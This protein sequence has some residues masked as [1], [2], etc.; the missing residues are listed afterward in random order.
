MKSQSAAEAAISWLGWLFHVPIEALTAPTEFGTDL[1][2]TFTSDF[3]E[4][5]LATVS[6]EVLYV[7]R[8]MRQSLSAAEPVRSVGDFCSLI[9]H[10]QEMDPIGY[11]RLLARWQKHMT[12]GSKP[13][14]RRFV[15]KAFGV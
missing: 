15:F 9:V 5:E 6:E 7:R 10:Y 1:K 14:W 13:K 4:N 12:I 8:C 11:E 3:V 2:P